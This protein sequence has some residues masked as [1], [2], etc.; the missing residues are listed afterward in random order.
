MYVHILLEM[1]YVCIYWGGGG[2]TVLNNSPEAQ[3]Q[4]HQWRRMA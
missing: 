1:F 4:T 3:F 2:V